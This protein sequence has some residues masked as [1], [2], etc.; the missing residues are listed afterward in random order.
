MKLQSDN[1]YID[2][3]RSNSD[4]SLDLKTW[5]DIDLFSSSLHIPNVFRCNTEDANKITFYSIDPSVK[6]NNSYYIFDKPRPKID[7]WNKWPI[8][9]KCV[10][11][12]I[13]AAEDIDDLNHAL[14]PHIDEGLCRKIIFS[15]VSDFTVIKGVDKGWLYLKRSLINIIKHYPDMDRYSNYISVSID[16]KSCEFLFNVYPTYNNE[17]KKYL[18]MQFESSGGIVFYSKD[19]DL[20]DSSYYFSGKIHTSKKIRKSYKINYLLSFLHGDF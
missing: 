17:N 8:T 15:V 11:N 18:I 3:F 6:E 1:D 12:E 9:F 7:D 2:G 19:Y 4:V 14:M 16:D 13:L 20:E 10:A 5:R